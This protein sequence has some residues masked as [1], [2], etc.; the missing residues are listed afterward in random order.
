MATRLPE[1]FQL[2]PEECLRLMESEIL[3]RFEIHQLL[4]KHR[5]PFLEDAV[6]ERVAGGRVYDAQIG[7]M[8]RQAGVGVVVTENVRHFFALRRHGIRVVP[9]AELGET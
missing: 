9:A 2:S 4:P 5:R 7:E 3:E 6:A 8:A 1:E